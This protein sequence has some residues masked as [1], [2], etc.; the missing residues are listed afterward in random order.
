[1]GEVLKPQQRNTN[2]GGI[3]TSRIVRRSVDR[4]GQFRFRAK[5]SFRYMN[6]LN[7]STVRALYNMYRYVILFFRF[8]LLSD[9]RDDFHMFGYSWHGISDSPEKLW[10][11][12]TLLNVF[13]KSIHFQFKCG[14]DSKART[15][16]LFICPIGISTKRQQLRSFK[17]ET[18]R[19]AKIQFWGATIYTSNS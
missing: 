1:M 9:F 10:Q 2:N 12:H 4:R 6:F 19:A 3:P 13:T 8:Y 14:D 15:I 17:A 18:K 16:S 11:I 7:N 5:S